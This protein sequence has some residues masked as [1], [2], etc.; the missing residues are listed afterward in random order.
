MTSYLLDTCTVIWIA[1][2]EP[3]SQ[4]A[5]DQ[6]SSDRDGR[7][8]IS[9]ITAWEVAQLVA[10][11]KLA[12]SI[13]PQVWYERL[14]DSPDIVQAELSPSVLISSTTLPDLTITDPA[15]RILIATAREFGFTLVTRDQ[16][17]LNYGQS[18]HVKVLRC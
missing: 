15:D 12:L 16:K 7:L 5:V 13:N 10:K 17:I 8:Y 3:L 6:L 2:G 14:F 1:N 4:P 9:P 18:G 11:G